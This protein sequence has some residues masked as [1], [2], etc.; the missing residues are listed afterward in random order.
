MHTILSFYPHSLE[1]W[2]SII[3]FYPS[4]SPTLVTLYEAHLKIL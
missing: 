3:F 1:K 2:T 4:F